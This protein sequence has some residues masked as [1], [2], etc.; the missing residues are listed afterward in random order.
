LQHE[1]GMILVLVKMFVKLHIL[2]W[3]DEVID[4]MLVLVSIFVLT[5]IHQQRSRTTYMLE[6]LF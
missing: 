3:G 2:T 5:Y 1:T 6:I 4:Y